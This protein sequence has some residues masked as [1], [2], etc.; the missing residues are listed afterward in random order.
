MYSAGRCWTRRQTPDKRAIMI[1][2]AGVAKPWKPGLHVPTSSITTPW[3]SMCA[4]VMLGDGSVSKISPAVYAAAKRRYNTRVSHLAM[5]R[6]RPG[7]ENKMALEGYLA[8]A[9]SSCVR[10]AYFLPLECTKGVVDKEKKATPSIPNTRILFVNPV[11]FRRIVTSKPVCLGTREG[12]ERSEIERSIAICYYR[13][14]GS[15]SYIVREVHSVRERERYRERER[16]RE[17]ER[18]TE[19]TSPLSR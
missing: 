3:R 17:R 15:A 7:N 11:S 18:K 5:V 8:R 12:A 10:L 2:L 19:V 13:K 6:W 1:L 14:R 4:V 16:Q 9:S